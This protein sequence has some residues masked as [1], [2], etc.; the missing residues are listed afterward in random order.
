MLLNLRFALYQ[1]FFQSL[2]NLRFINL[3]SI[4]A[5]FVLALFYIKADKILFFFD[6]L[7]K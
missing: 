3:F 5:K 4:F 7:V 6:F 2:R 1:S